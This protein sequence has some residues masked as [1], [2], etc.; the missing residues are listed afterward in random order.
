MARVFLMLIPYHF[1]LSKGVFWVLSI[2]F[3]IWKKTTIQDAIFIF[4]V[5]IKKSSPLRPRICEGPK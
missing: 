1:D 4:D 5:A 2:E 3:C